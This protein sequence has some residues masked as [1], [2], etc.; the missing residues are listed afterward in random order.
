MLETLFKLAKDYDVEIVE[1]SH[2]HFQIRG[3]LLVNYYP[4]SAKQTAYVDGTRQGRKGVSPLEAM[5]M[6]KTAPPVARPEHRDKRRSKKSRE[7]RQWLIEKRGITHC[8][9][10]NC[11]L[12][13]DTSTLEHVIPLNRGGLDQPGNW[14][15]A[16]GPCNEDR[17]GDMPELSQE[18]KPK[19]TQLSLAEQRLLLEL[20]YSEV[21]RVYA[22]TEAQQPKAS[23]EE[24]QAIKARLGVLSSELQA[25]RAKLKALNIKIV[26]AQNRHYQALFRKVAQDKLPQPLFEE[27]D[28]LTKSL[29]EAIPEE[30]RVYDL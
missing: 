21:R 4:F 25:L 3:D 1:R 20:R 27:L 28:R 10:C 13:L 9:W 22:E 30:E 16:C 17:G 6:A 5:Q 14:T 7:R 2:G 18:A 12:T 26:N 29:Y 23:Q 19:P 15:L 24:R 8:R 11:S